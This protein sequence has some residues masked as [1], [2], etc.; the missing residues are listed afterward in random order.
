MGDLETTAGTQR[1]AENFMAYPELRNPFEATPIHPEG[2]STVLYQGKR[3]TLDETG[4]GDKLLIRP[5]DLPRINGF[6]LKPEGACLDALCI[7]V[8]DTLLVMQDGRQWFDLEGFAALLEQPYV[9]DRAARVWSFAEL[10]LKREHMLLQAQAPDLEL[11]D[12]QGNVF[13]L[14]DLK[15]KKALIVTW[16]SW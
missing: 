16:S 12:R 6:E 14:A 1:V 2:S 10:P 11:T 3:I 5:E 4:A 9:V 13:T 15:G 7:P 8:N